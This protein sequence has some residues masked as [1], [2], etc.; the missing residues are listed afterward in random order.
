MI[1]QTVLCLVAGLMLSACNSPFMNKVGSN[2][3]GTSQQPAGPLVAAP[4]GAAQHW[5]T[6][7]NRGVK[8]PIS[9]LQTNKGVEIWVAQDG[10]QVF[11]RDGMII[12][13]RGLGQ[14]LMSASAPTL[15]Q[16]RSKANHKREMFQMDGTDTMQREVFD[17]TVADAESDPAFSQ[18]RVLDELC[19]SP[20][21]VIR[22]KF[23]FGT[24]GNLLKSR[25]WTTK[26]VGFAIIEVKPAE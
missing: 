10:A 14:D 26:G 23:Y 25:Q 19:E 13:T 16:I 2:L 20:L 1:R 8:F 12:G 15:A 17:C 24:S 9:K 18:I 11:L 22:N 5:M 4:A 7:A 21:R 3:V 6:L